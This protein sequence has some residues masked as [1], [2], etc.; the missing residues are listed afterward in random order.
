[1][2]TKLKNRYSG[3]IFFTDNYEDVRKVNNNEFI[4]I[5][6]EANPKRKYL[7][8]RDAFEIID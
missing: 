3:D 6:S 4:L 8:N 1:M 7:A 5:Y 2:S